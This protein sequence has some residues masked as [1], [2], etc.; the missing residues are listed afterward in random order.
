MH[1]WVAK[2]VAILKISE[3][4]LF[5]VQAL[6]LV[7]VFMDDYAWE[8]PIAIYIKNLGWDH[9]IRNF[10]IDDRNATAVGN[11][12]AVVTGVYE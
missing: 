7:A 10:K 4:T 9:V 11:S 1:K 5:F 8:I 2:M 12:I 3:E 6:P